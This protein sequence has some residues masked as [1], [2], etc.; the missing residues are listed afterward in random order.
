MTVTIYIRRKTRS[1]ASES[2]ASGHVNNQDVGRLY[3]LEVAYCEYETINPPID[4][5]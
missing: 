2:E 3:I 4:G 5:R 1:V